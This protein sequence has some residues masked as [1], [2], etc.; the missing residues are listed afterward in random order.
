MFFFGRGRSLF[1]NI[2]WS[3]KMVLVLSDFDVMHKMCRKSLSPV[4]HLDEM[5]CE[6]LA[7]QKNPPHV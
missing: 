2:M 6:T 5:H 7:I 3:Q 1:Q 4:R